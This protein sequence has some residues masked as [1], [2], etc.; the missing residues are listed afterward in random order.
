MSEELGFFTKEQEKALAEVIDSAIEAKGFVEMM[1]GFVARIAISVVDNELL[2]KRLVK[3]YELSDVFVEDIRILANQVLNKEYIAAAE[4]GAL[5]VNELVDIPG[6]SEDDE[7]MIFVGF[8]T[9]IVG[10]ITKKAKE[11]SLP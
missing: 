11:S 3:A 5:I 9:M 10:A 4:T 2:E 7:T 1:D 8:L 6:L